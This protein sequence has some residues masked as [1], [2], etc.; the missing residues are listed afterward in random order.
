MMLLRTS[1]MAALFRSQLQRRQLKR[2]LY[3][4]HHKRRAVN[5]GQGDHTYFAWWR[6][7]VWHPLNVLRRHCKPLG[8]DLVILGLYHGLPIWLIM[9]FVG[10]VVRLVSAVDGTVMKTARGSSFKVATTD[11]IA[12]ACSAAAATRRIFGH[13]AWSRNNWT[14]ISNI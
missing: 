3:Q 6:D 8:Y 13:H 2:R 4:G 10:S 7:E 5:W 12:R 11:I 9:A 14:G 1:S